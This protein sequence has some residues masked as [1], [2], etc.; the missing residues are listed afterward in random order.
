[1]ENKA[2]GNNAASEFENDIKELLNSSD[3]QCKQDICEIEY[4]KAEGLM[5][6]NKKES[7]VRAL[8]IMNG[9]SV[10]FDYIP[11]LMWMG[12][13]F[14][15]VNED[16]KAAAYFAKASTLGDGEGARCYA[17]MLMIGKGVEQN[18]SLACEQYL[19]AS[20]RGVPEAMFVIGQFYDR[21]G[22]KEKAYES[23]MNAYKNGYEPAKE[24]MEIVKTKAQSNAIR[25]EFAYLK[26]RSDELSEF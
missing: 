25:F 15:S 21:A 2:N 24:L 19:I 13:F 7:V 20:Q 6:E 8:G 18:E 16:R 3:V 12:H 9:L 4:K 11:A 17:D 26:G 5:N 14:E 22:N 23:Y 1:M 10:K